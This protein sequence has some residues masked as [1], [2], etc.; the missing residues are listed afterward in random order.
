L[1]AQIT[2][3]DNEI[4]SAI[5]RAQTETETLLDA[6]NKGLPGYM[7]TGTLIDTSKSNIWE[8]YSSHCVSCGACVTI[9]PTCSCFL[10]IDKPGFEKVKQMDG[11]Q[12]PGF[13]RVAGGRI[14]WVN[15]TT[16]S[17]TGICVNMSGNLK[18]SFHPPVR[19]AGDV[20]RH[21]S[22]RS[23]RMRYSWNW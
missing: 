12:Y 7:E 6:A 13:E 17:G 3:A 22:D 15:F 23:I 14:L 21:A 4:I 9:C 16:G 18:N 8:K 1:Q 19:D 5:E 20:L 10:L 11:C 2:A